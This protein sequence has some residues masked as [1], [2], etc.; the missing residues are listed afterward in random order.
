MAGGK[1]KNIT[2]QKLLDSAALLF[3]E[4]GYACTSVAEICEAAGANIASVNYHFHSK[5]ALYQEVIKYTY[6]QA[7]RLYPLF[8][9]QETE[10]EKKLYQLILSLLKRILSTESKGNFYKLVAK[11]MADPT[12]ASGTLIT[13]IIMNKRARIQEVIKEIHQKP[14]SEELLFMMTHSIVSQCLF[15]GV[16]ERGRQHHLKRPPITFGDAEA[17]ARHITDFSL[18]G[19]NCYGKGNH[20]NSCELKR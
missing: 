12:E 18:A 5:E 15:L 13:T 10:V 8:E 3:S 4:K 1:K 2:R 11:E 17:I 9:A 20:L 7:E 19:I 16:H 6:E 14:V